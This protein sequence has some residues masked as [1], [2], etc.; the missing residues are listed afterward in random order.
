M[1]SDVCIFVDDM[2]EAV[3]YYKKLLGAIPDHY[4]PH[5]R[6]KGFFRAAG[7]VKEAAQEEL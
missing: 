7:F 3:S 1:K 2:M 5:W 4:L 6:N